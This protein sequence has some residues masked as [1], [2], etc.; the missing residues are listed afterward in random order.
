M[1]VRMWHGKVPNNKAAAYR[2]F[3]SAR[4]IPDY[5]SVEG[6]ISVHVLER[7][8][9]EVTHFVTLTFWRSLEDIKRFAGQD[10]ERAK[11]YDEDKD[12]LIEFEPN[13]VHY[14]V[15]GNSS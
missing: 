4:A 6:N 7:M 10:V 11:Y 12:Y 3:L 1:I 2:S 14:Q 8:E 9:G 13:V 5:K 15:V